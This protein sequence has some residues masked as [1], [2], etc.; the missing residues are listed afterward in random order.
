[1][2]LYE[3]TAYL[4]AKSS[5]PS[6]LTDEINLEITGYPWQDR[7]LQV[8]NF[9]HKYNIFQ[10]RGFLLNQDIAYIYLLNKQ[11]LPFSPVDLGV[12]YIYNQGDIRIYQVLK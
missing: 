3:T 10:A 11:N 9:F 1:M 8:A 2:Y 12:K 4:S 5:Q 7:Q 6:Y